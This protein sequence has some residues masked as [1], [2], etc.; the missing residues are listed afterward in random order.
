[1][2]QMDRLRG[3][4]VSVQAAANSP[5]APVEVITAMA[6]A[7]EEGGAV[8]LRIEGCK[9]V[10]A[11]KAA[12]RVPVIGLIKR[13]YAQF[14]PYITPTVAEVEQLLAAAADIIAF[15]ATLRSRP[16]ATT[17]EQLVDRIKRGGAVPMADCSTQ[18]DAFAAQRLGAP[19][20]ATTLCGYTMETAGMKLPA[21][22]L[23][24]AL[25]GCGALVVCE[26]GVRDASDVRAARDAGADAIVVG[27]AITNI[28]S[29]TAQFAAPLHAHTRT[30]ATA[31]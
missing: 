18:D 16:A 31:V 5:L 11:V 26:G 7:A 22:Q 24:R 10:A 17:V 25:C 13:S 28:A 20:L 8:A 21:I 12:V 9:N 14:E 27:T 30:D 4:I 23:V 2:I 3:L 19:I 1:M 29:V 6:R 15:D